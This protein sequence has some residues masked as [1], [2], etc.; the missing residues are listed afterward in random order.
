[1]KIPKISIPKINMASVK[2][3]AKN[4]FTKGKAFVKDA[5]K[6][7]K[8]LAHDTV[9]FVKHNPKKAGVYVLAGVGALAVLNGVKEIAKAG[10]EK[11]QA[12]KYE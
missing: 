5:P 1:M 11:V 8:T 6:N 9:D 2:N 7:V 3:T 10:V 12:R 4:A